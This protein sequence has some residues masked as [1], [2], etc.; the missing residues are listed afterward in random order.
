M[1][2]TADLEEAID[3]AQKRHD[4]MLAA[5][6]RTKAEYEEEH[7]GT[8][9][10]CRVPDG[11]HSETISP[12]GWCERHKYPSDRCNIVRNGDRYLCRYH[13]RYWETGICPGLQGPFA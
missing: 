5:V 6:Y 8:W 4:E 12:Y 10:V 3:A 2:G 13:N 7:K 11:P 1:S 9:V